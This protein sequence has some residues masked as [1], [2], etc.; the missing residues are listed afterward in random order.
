MVVMAPAEWRSRVPTARPPRA[1]TEKQAAT[2]SSAG[3]GVPG[4]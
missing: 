3:I 2:P 4:A 1:V